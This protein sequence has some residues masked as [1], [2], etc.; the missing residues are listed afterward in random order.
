M[1]KK[2][3]YVARACQV[4]WQVVSTMFV[5]QWCPV[6]LS[7]GQKVD[8]GTSI[9]D[10]K[11]S[12]MN[13]QDM[14]LL[15]LYHVRL[16]KVVWVVARVVGRGEVSVIKSPSKWTSLIKK[17]DL[18]RIVR[19]GR[20]YFC[21]HHSPSMPQL[22]AGQCFIFCCQASLAQARLFQSS[23]SEQQQ[24]RS[25]AALDSY[26]HS[27]S[28]VFVVVQGLL[29]EALLQSEEANWNHI[30]KEW[31]KKT[32]ISWCFKESLHTW[33]HCT[34]YETPTCLCRNIFVGWPRYLNICVIRVES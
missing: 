34:P 26:L 19:M 6:A 7:D 31:I 29:R 14:S 17:A 32:I 33:C 30:M 28:S 23:G 15:Y 13:W 10:I 11:R 21:C 1:K 27:L 3:H 5:H 20:S 16:V 4:R 2:L 24:Q 8:A 22:S 25:P 9:F 12:E 18:A